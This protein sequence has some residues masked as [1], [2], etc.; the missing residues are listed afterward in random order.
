MKSRFRKI[1]VFSDVELVKLGQSFLI[2][3]CRQNTESC[4]QEFLFTGLEE[5][6]TFDILEIM[7][8]RNW[9]LFFRNFDFQTKENHSRS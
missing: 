8:I 7:K 3:L 5:F 6:K 2:F 9:K 4:R 1:V